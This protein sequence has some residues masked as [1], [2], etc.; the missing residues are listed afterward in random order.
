MPPY[1]IVTKDYLK[2]VFQEK[3]DFFKMSE[4]K[5]CNPPAYDEI[6]VKALYDKILKQQNMAKFFPDK[7]PKG[8]Q[9]DRSY[10]YNIW[11]TVHPEQVKAVIEHANEVRY[12]SKNER[13][14][15]ESI[16]ITDKWE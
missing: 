7:L 5:F 3:K 2:D 6:G 12:G 13:M 4:V 9:M 16:K 8:R 15:D 10:M 1:D 11:N 14:Q